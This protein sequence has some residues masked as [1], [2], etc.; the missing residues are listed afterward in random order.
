MQRSLKHTCCFSVC[1][2]LRVTE[3]ASVVDTVV[4]VAINKNKR[5]CLMEFKSA[6]LQIDTLG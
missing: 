3:V 2:D 1:V 6:I 4:A 5:S